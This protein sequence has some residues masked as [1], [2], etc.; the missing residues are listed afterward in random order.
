M[1]AVNPWRGERLCKIAG[2]DVKMTCDMD[3]LAKVFSLLKAQSL[4]ELYEKLETKHPD[5]L[6]SVFLL[7][8]GEEQGEANWP[9]V[10][11][12]VGMANIY[13]TIISTLSGQTPEEEAEAE[14]KR[15]AAQEAAEDKIR[16]R[17]MDHLSG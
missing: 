9:N 16:E 3:Q 1:A 2:S 5:I 4:S 14:K 6:K 7:L 17:V 11:G 15:L 10:V 12:I 8:A 13:S